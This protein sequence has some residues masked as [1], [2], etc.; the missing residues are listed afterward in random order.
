MPHEILIDRHPIELREATDIGRG[1]AAG[2]LRLQRRENGDLLIMIPG[3]ATRDGAPVLGNL[4]IVARGE[5]AL[6]RATGCC[7]EIVWQDRAGRR[8][9]EA[10]RRCRLCFGAF[11]PDE[12][13]AACTCESVFHADCDD[14]RSDC[15]GCG[16]ARERES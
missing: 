3:D 4:A 5:G 9:V 10:G 15:P 12:I 7:V 14:L 11:A 13:A 16:A 8:P 6:V 1:G 2:L